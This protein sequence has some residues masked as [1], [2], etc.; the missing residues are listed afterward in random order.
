MPHLLKNHCSSSFNN[1]YE[2][3]SSLSMQDKRKKNEKKFK[4]TISCV[5]IRRQS[6]NRKILKNSQTMHQIL[7]WSG[8]ELVFGFIAQKILL[9]PANI[10]LLTLAIW[11]RLCLKN[12]QISWDNFAYYI[13]ERLHYKRNK[14]SLIWLARLI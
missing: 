2:D 6:Y 11:I 13:K 14:N 8:W 9:K 10:L 3:K 5:I 4:S 1:F 7:R 12:S